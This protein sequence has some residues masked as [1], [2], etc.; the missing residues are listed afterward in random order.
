MKVKTGLL[1]ADTNTLVVVTN[2]VV[3]IYVRRPPYPV[4]RV[5]KVHTLITDSNYG[6]EPNSLIRTLSRLF[7]PPTT[8]GS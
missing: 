6:T 1:A 4:D 5:V 2:S 3:V 8:S 7:T